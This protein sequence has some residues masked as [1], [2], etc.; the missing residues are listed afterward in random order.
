MIDVPGA[1]PS[2]LV[3]TLGKD[4]NAYL[5]DRNNP[6]GITSPV[7]QAN[8]VA[9]ATNR[10]TSAVTYHTSQG[11]YF[12]FHDD[13]NAIAAYKVTA[14]NPQHDRKRLDCRPERP[15]FTLGHNN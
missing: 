10:G 15:R 7:A 12:A 11:T 2:Q 8:M 6:S 9:G 1:T 3:L 14:T 5:I 13:G 4:Q